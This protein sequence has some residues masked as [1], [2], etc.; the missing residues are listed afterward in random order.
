LLEILEILF[1]VKTILV[2][3][4]DVSI[5][6]TFRRVLEKSGYQIDTVDTAA[7][8]LEKL[9]SRRYDLAIIDVILPDMKGTDLLVKAKEDLKMTIKFIITG[10][11]STEVGAK[12]RDYGADAFILKPVKMDELLSIIHTFL[13]DFEEAP[14]EADER[15]DKFALSEVKSDLSH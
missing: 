9:R 2:V 7:L 3:D 11:P 15:E 8:A 6:R 10:Y 1:L 13:G 4:D 14:Y 12:A 5:L